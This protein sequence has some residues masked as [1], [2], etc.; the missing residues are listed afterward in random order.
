MYKKI[1]IETINICDLCGFTSVRKVELKNDDDKLYKKFENINLCKE[2]Y[3]TPNEQK[4]NREGVNSLEI[5][6]YYK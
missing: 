6:Y 2:C 3:N 5:D 4:I 1:M